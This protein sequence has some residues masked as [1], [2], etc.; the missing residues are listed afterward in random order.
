MGATFQVSPDPRAEFEDLVGKHFRRF[1]NFA[2]RLTGNR[3]DA[4]DVLQ[5][6]LLRAYRA[7]AS[8]DRQK[9]FESWVFQILTNLAIDLLRRRRKRKVVSLN[10]PPTLEEDGME[11]WEIPSED[12]GPDELVERKILSRE[13]ELALRALPEGYRTVLLLCDVEEYS[14]QEIAE[15]TCVSIGT[16]RSRIHRARSMLRTNYL[17]NVN[18]N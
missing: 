17:R 7:F 15:I 4:E 2:Y 12:P 13:M 1:Y 6:A 10:R 16:V 14:Y 18:R 11:G 3:E 8:Y 9:P 5:E